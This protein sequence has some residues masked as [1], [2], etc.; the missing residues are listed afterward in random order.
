ML[1][2]NTRGLWGWKWTCLRAYV[3]GCLV[4][5]FIGPKVN[6]Q[7]EGLRKGGC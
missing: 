3:E 1:A 5:I 7:S 4:S 6:I 2:E